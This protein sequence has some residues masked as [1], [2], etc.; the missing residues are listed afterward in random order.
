[1]CCAYS[2]HTPYAA[3]I[4]PRRALLFKG[5]LVE[6]SVHVQREN[7]R[8]RETERERD[9]TYRRAAVDYYITIIT[10]VVHSRICVLYYI[11]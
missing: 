6:T 9:F 7:C 5:I 10:V 8:E 1:M 4:C 2:I 11:M 3:A